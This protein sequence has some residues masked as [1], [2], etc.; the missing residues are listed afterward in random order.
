M[1]EIVGSCIVIPRRERVYTIGKHTENIYH[2]ALRMLDNVY[3][4]NAYLKTR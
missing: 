2:E 4:Y 3:H 1:M